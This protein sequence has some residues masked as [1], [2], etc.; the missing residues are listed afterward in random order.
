MKI[1]R[2]VMLYS[3]NVSV[4]RAVQGVFISSLA[5]TQAYFS[6]VGT[7]KLHPFMKAE[8]T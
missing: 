3:E 8:Q 7:I 5:T 1:R 6:I 4:F 2:R